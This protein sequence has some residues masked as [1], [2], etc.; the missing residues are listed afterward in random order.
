MRRR[1][2]DT[3]E[4]LVKEELDAALGAPKSARV[5]EERH[6]YRHGTRE[7]TVTTSL[8][9]RRLPCRGP[10]CTTA[11]AAPASGE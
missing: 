1:I 10:V 2:R 6:G 3:I 5:G 4:E 11:T 8:A 7:R 9:R